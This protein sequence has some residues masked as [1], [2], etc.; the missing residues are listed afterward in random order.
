VHKPKIL[1]RMERAMSS[2]DPS[3]VADCFTED[4]RCA[5][6]LAAVIATY[7]DAAQGPPRSGARVRGRRARHRDAHRAH[8]GKAGSGPLAE[9]VE[10]RLQDV[11]DLDEPGAYDLIWLCP[12]ARSW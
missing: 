10:L 4:Y 3:Q 5:I 8:P 1:D 6:P 12:Q 2:Q 7:R 9:R 11:A